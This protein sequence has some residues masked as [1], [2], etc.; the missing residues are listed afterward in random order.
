MLGLEQGPPPQPLLWRLGGHPLGP[1]SLVL[2]EAS[3]QLETLCQAAFWD[4]AVFSDTPAVTELILR[5]SKDMHLSGQA[6]DTMMQGEGVDTA[7]AIEESAA[8]VRAVLSADWPLRRALL[9]GLG[10]FA[11]A[12]GQASGR[13]S[14]A[15]AS[16]VSGVQPEEAA[17]HGLQIVASLQEAINNTIEKVGSHVLFDEFTFYAFRGSIFMS[18][19]SCKCL[20]V[21]VAIVCGW[22][23]V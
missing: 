19:C 20:G 12:V 14:A 9:E 8:T 16:L 22:L 7:V 13:K 5:A 11:M 4:G 1:P 17:A 6:V 10:M 23:D 2:W 21:L 15:A 3:R 18:I